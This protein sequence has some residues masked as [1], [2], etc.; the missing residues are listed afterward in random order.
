MTSFSRQ[1]PLKSKNKN[2]TIVCNWKVCYV[3]KF[4]L[5]WIKN[6]KVIPRVPLQASCWPGVCICICLFPDNTW[7]TKN[8]PA[9]KSGIRNSSWMHGQMLQSCQWQGGIP[10]WH[11]TN[12]KACAVPFL[13]D[14]Y[15]SIHL[16]MFPK[17]CKQIN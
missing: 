15:L 6:T 1:N 11:I 9:L 14:L 7:F 2:H 16:L 13:Q 3:A 5:H 4:E 12:S 10:H 8:S 17:P